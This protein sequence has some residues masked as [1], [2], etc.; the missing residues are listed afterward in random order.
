M[1]TYT[2]AADRREHILEVACG[3]AESTHYREIRRH[4]L[5]EACGTAAGNITRVMGGMDGLRD[6]LVEFAIRHGRHHVV[7]Q[8]IADKHPATLSLTSEQRAQALETF[9]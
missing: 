5:V 1:S 7:A 9:A 6:L 4:H 2:K 3:L 8:A